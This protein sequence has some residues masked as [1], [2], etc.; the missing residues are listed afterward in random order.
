MLGRTERI[1]AMSFLDLV[2]YTRLTEG[3]GDRA[4]A[5]LAE[6]LAVLVNRSAREHGG[7]PV[8]WLGDGVTVHYREPAGA[9]RS[10]LGLVAQLPEA[11]LPPAHVPAFLPARAPAGFPRRL[12][13][14]DL[15]GLLKARS[16]LTSSRFFPAEP[17]DEAAPV[18]ASRPPARSAALKD[19]SELELRKMRTHAADALALQLTPEPLAGPV[20]EVLVD[21]ADG[22]PG[23]LVPAAPGR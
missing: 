12:E 23:R 4:A 8:K 13:C 16:M 20:G 9:V 6:T 14:P 2:G 17:D 19:A 15:V 3:R 1:P 7:V 5:A 11:C 18:G 21:V 10:A 22:V